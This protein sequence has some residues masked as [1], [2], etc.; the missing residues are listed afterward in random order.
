M[1]VAALM[2]ASGLALLLLN[3]LMQRTADRLAR[4][5]RNSPFGT[6]FNAPVVRPRICAVRQNY[7]AELE[8]H[9]HTSDYHDELLESA[10]RAVAQLSFFRSRT[11]AGAHSGKQVHTV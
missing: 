4:V 10:R 9:A 11:K 2:F 8:A 5:R 7:V 6:A 1:F 3:A